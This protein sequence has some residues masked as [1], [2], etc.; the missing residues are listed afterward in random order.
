MLMLPRCDL[1]AAVPDWFQNVGDEIGGATE[2]DTELVLAIPITSVAM[3][4]A[5]TLTSSMDWA[6]TPIEGSIA[7][8]DNVDSYWRASLIVS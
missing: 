8:G 1:S 3:I 6:P 2:A 7:R 5:L 4:C